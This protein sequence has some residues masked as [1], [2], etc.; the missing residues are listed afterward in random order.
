[1]SSLESTPFFKY[2][3]EVYLKDLTYM[4]IDYGP[5]LHSIHLGHWHY[6]HQGSI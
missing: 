3:L 5:W 1:M 6:F 2:R 4:Q